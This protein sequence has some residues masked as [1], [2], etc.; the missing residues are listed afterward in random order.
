MR[1][2]SLTY[3]THPRLPSSVVTKEGGGRQAVCDMNGYLVV[4][5]DVGAAYLCKEDDPYSSANP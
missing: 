1:P 2:N 4:E 5:A 3:P